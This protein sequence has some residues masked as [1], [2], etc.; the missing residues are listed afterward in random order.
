[1]HLPL[2]FSHICIYF[3]DGN[4]YIYHIVSFFS[5]RPGRWGVGWGEEG[6][7]TWSAL[8]LSG[9]S[10]F[11]T[12]THVAA[13]RL[14]LQDKRWLRF[15]LLWSFGA[16]TLHYKYCNHLYFLVRSEKPVF[17]ISKND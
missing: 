4:T 3:K 16:A 2:F 9:L 17:L 11:R 6:R 1:M 13:S 10:I 8:G 14:P 5:S 7:I 15:L 12:C